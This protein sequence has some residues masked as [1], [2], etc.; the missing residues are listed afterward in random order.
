MFV[1]WQTNK[2]RAKNPALRKARHTQLKAILVEA[3][4]VAGEPRLHHLAY[5]GST[6]TDGSDRREFWINVKQQFKRLRLAP[7]DR[8]RLTAAIVRKVGKP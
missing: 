6:S 1:R 3:R 5:L 2:S 7:E 4:R 8:R